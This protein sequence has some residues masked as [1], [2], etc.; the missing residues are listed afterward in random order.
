MGDKKEGKSSQYFQTIARHFFEHRGAPFF[1]S[2]KELDLIAQWEKIGIPLRVVLEGMKKSLETSLFGIRKK[3]KIFSLS[4][5]DY[6]VLKA[7]QQ[8]RDRQV[9]KGERVKEREEKK[10]KAQ[11]EVGRFLKTMPSQLFYLI[12]V[13][14]RA[15][16]VLSGKDVEEEELERLEGKIEELLFSRTTD[17]EK[18]RV[19]K[20]V[21]RE[22]GSRNEEDLAPI[23]KIKL[24]KFLREEYKIPYI[25][26]FYY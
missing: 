20:E 25:S 12:D 10:K 4:Y 7:F 17:Q 22:Y 5:C 3:G 15:Q 23:Q 21:R 13:Y 1:L 6:Q 26:L 11:A 24:V 2:S 9:G 19:K 8:Y 18:E 16:R 14:S